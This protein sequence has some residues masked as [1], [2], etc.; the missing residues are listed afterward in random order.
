MEL[1]L[2]NSKHL[3]WEYDMKQ[4]NFDKSYKIVIER[5]LQRGDLQQWRA[6]FHFYGK[7]KM[8]ET[9]NWS[10]QLEERD[11][12]FSKFFLQSDLLN[13]A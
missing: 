3:L 1:L 9:I 11:K 4:F 8:I 5:V 12:R 6:I 2:N 7:E 13:A 10:S